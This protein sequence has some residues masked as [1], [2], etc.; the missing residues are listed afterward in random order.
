MSDDDAAFGP[1]EA[2]PLSGLQAFAAAQGWDFFGDKLNGPDVEARSASTAALEADAVELGKDAAALFET[3]QG[4]A[5][6][7]WLC[8][9]TVRRPAWF[10]GLPRD[11]ADLYMAMR[12]GQNGLLFTLLKL[13]ASGREEKPPQ[14]QG[15]E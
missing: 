10:F 7:E 6:L 8:D 5:V 13:I 12:E 9:V 15:V 1:R 2:Q 14:R 4:R 11:Q 3:R